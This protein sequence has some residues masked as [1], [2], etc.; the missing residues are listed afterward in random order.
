MYADSK[1]I[2]TGVIDSPEVLQRV[3]HY[4]I[5]TL[6]WFLMREAK[7]DA[8]KQ[9]LSVK[10]DEVL[11]FNDGKSVSELDEWPSTDDSGLANPED[12]ERT[13]QWAKSVANEKRMKGEM[14]KT[15][16]LP[17]LLDNLSDIVGEEE[18]SPLKR[19][20]LLPPLHVRPEPLGA[21]GEVLPGGIESERT[22]QSVRKRDDTVIGGEEMSPFSFANEWELLSQTSPK[23]LKP[24][25]PRKWFEGLVES[26]DLGLNMVKSLTFHCFDSVYGGNALRGGP[27]LAVKVFSGKWESSNL[28]KSLEEKV[29]LPSFRAALKIALDE[30][31][32]SIVYEENDLKEALDELDSNW[33]LGPD[34]DINWRKAVLEKKPNLFSVQMDD[35]SGRTLFKSRR[36]TFRECQVNLAKLNAEVV[37]GL[38]ASMALELLYL[39]N[40]DDER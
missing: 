35:N 20:T 28:P 25:Y 31:L 37:K 16:S 14:N 40:D 9:N 26:N 27:S 21:E 8:K 5:Y 4:F 13:A 19:K 17:S 30:V 12:M 34:D 38:W 15:G 1:N 36:L 29:L 24:T 33:H 32:L 10:N 39:T 11:V 7:F 3:A 23:C 18:F 22:P 2:L 6:P